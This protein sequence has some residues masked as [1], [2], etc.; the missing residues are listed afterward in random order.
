MIKIIGLLFFLPFIDSSLRGIISI[1]V[2]CNGLLC[3][4]S[5]YLDLHHSNKFMIFDVICNF[6]MG[7][8]VLYTT[9]QYLIFISSVFFMSVSNLFFIIILVYV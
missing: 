6:F 1:V 2:I 5:H 3:H 4:G 8:F 7:V 9:P